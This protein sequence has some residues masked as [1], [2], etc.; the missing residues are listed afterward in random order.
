MVTGGDEAVHDGVALEYHSTNWGEYPVPLRSWLTE[1]WKYVETIGG[2][3][4]LYDLSEDPLERVNL[5]QDPRAVGTRQKMKT[6]L[7]RW[8][9]NTSDSWPNVPMPDRG[10]VNPGT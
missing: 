4:E 9:E 1:D 2:D 8:L 7:Y 10:V 3:D 6:A 5:I